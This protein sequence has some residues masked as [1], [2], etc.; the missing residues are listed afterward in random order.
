MCYLG[1]ILNPETFLLKWGWKIIQ[2]DGFN[3]A[4][5]I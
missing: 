3:M 1:V 2:N 4:R 5:Q